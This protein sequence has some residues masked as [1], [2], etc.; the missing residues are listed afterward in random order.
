[1][2]T[3]YK[4]KLGKDLDNV[5]HP[6]ED[7]TKAS[8]TNYR[9]GGSDLNNRY[10]AHVDGSKI[11]YSTGYKVNGTDLKDIFA[12]KGSVRMNRSM[13]PSCVGRRLAFIMCNDNAAADCN[14]RI[15]VNGTAVG[16]FIMN[17]HDYIGGVAIGRAPGDPDFRLTQ[18]PVYCPP[19]KLTHQ[20][21]DENLLYFNA[22]NSIF[23]RNIQNTN[24]G[25]KGSVILASFGVGGHRGINLSN[26]KI[27]VDTAYHGGSGENFGPYNFFFTSC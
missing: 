21:F 5:F 12:E 1:M 17:Q 26:P 2:T 19:S 3:P 15:E 25:N 10:A 6:L 27:I 7:N 11:D 9:V 24:N 23:C 14:F 13:V 22:N 4:D 18:T 20:Y 8:K 16:D